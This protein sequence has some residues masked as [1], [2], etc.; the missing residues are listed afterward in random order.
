MRTMLQPRSPTHIY[1]AYMLPYLR[2]IHV[3]MYI[4]GCDARNAWHGYMTKPPKEKGL[5]RP[6]SIRF[7]S[8]PWSVGKVGEY[9]YAQKETRDA[10]LAVFSFT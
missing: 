8:Y 1:H 7:C 9:I 2:T 3:A 5:G 6:V 10:P 4:Y